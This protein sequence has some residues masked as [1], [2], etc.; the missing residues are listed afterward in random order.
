M[1]IKIA[2]AYRTTSHEALCVLTGM[3]PI[4]IE[5]KSQARFYHDTWGN[6]QKEQYDARKPYSKW[7][8]PAETIELKEK[9]EGREYTVD[10]HTEGSKNSSG[11]GSGIAIFVN[12]CL[13]HQL[14]YK[15]AQKCSNSQVESLAIVKALETLQDF[16]HLQEKQRSTTIY[17]D[18]KITLE[19]TANARNHQNLVQQIRE[20]LRRLEKDNWTIHF[21]WMKANNNNLRNELADRLV[22]KAASRSEDGTA[23]SKIPK[24]AVIKEIQEIRE[25]EW[26]KE[27]N[28][29]NKGAIT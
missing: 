20:G 21:T 14:M 8:H 10:V 3:T 17:T 24:S 7:N 26:Q 22:K 11:V 16:N 18:S 23:Y 6:T 29:S 12:K 2:K 19:A 1:N 25:L 9:C 27:W 28:D 5:L 4:H 15:L 13:T